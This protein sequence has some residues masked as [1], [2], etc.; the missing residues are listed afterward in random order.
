MDTENPKKLFLGGASF[1]DTARMFAKFR[2]SLLI[3]IF[4]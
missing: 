3:G 2:F 1:I 4:K